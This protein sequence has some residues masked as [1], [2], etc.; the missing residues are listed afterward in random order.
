MATIGIDFDHTL[1]DGDVPK[2]FARE[3][4]NILREKGHKIVIHS[5]NNVKWIEKVLANND[6]RYDWIW[7]QKGKPI[8]DIYIDD[9]G[10]HYRGDWETEVNEVLLRLE[11]FDNRKFKTV[12]LS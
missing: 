12:T 3:A 11:G 6:I 7:D 10:Y 2:Q 4:I 8:C 5:C 9:K 1:V